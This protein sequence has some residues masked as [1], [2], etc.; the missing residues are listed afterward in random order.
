MIKLHRAVET[1]SVKS[2]YSVWVV[3]MPF[4]SV[5]STQWCRM[6]ALG[7][8][9]VKGRGGLSVPCFL[10]SYRSVLQNKKFLKCHFSPKHFYQCFFMRTPILNLLF[11]VASN[12]I[13]AALTLWENGKLKEKSTVWD[14]N[15][16][17]ILNNP[18]LNILCCHLENGRKVSGLIYG[19][20]LCICAQR[21]WGMR[22]RSAN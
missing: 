3:S 11:I 22:R 19:A 15:S 17:L 12:S 9:W 5:W 13:I 14:R 4:S 20:P 1:L 7:R 21:C 8:N 16:I 2:T 6:S 18:Y 10:L